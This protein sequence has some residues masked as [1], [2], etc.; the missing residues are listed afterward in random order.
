MYTTPQEL[1]L[2]PDS[3]T[4]DEWQTTDDSPLHK[5][6]YLFDTQNPFIYISGGIPVV[7][8]IGPFAYRLVVAVVD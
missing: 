6:Y 1:E 3:S 2:V 8:D 4:L 7:R 5:I